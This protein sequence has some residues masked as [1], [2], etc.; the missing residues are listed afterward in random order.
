MPGIAYAPC[1]IAYGTTRAA[2]QVSRRAGEQGACWRELVVMPMAAA[3]PALT[4]QAMNAGWRGEPMG[5]SEHGV[6]D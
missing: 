5:V 2:E 3:S 4:P 1:G 6:R